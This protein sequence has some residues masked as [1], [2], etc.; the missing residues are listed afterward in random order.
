MNT[1][2]G[3]INHPL[4]ELA[5]GPLWHPG[6]EHLYW[7]D[8][9]SR[10]LWRFTPSSGR[11]EMVWAGA[12]KVGGFAFRRGGGFALCTDKGI[13]TAD[14][15]LA[16]WTKLHDIPLAAGERF[17]DIT[18][19]PQGRIF[20][21]TMKR[22]LSDGALYRIQRG[23][24]PVRVLRNIG[25]SNGM[26]FSM[27]ERTFY[28][29]D[30]ITRCIT[31]FDYDAA[32]GKIS[33]PRVFY[34]GIECDGSPDGITLDRE[35]CIWVAC[36]GASQIIRLDPRGIIVERIPIP[37]K[38]PSSLI[39]GGARMNQL[40]VTT[41]CEGAHDLARGVDKEGCFLGGYLYHFLTDHVG[42]PEW[43]ADV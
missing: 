8:I 40:F 43:E 32:T 12:M 3:C 17:N 6:E 16:N 28:H 9:N 24:E 37:A 7:T 2:I 20:A 39:F 22:T 5:E 41:A 30:S 19:D 35:G 27:D 10:Q 36:W 14:T 33:G 11:T 42:R 21:G 15:A 18:T 26:T 4:C 23:K 31:A 13:F 34:Q 25:I 29:T 38:Q 1:G